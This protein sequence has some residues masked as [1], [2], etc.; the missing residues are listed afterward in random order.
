MFTFINAYPNSKVTRIIKITYGDLCEA[1]RLSQGRCARVTP[2]DAV[3]LE[4]N[5]N[6]TQIQH[7]ESATKFITRF[8]YAKL[9]AKSVGIDI[10]DSLLIDKFLV[11]I[12]SNK[13]YTSLIQTFQTQRR[14]ETLTPNHSLAQLTMTEVEIQ[15][16][17]IDENT[18]T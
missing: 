16:Y 5:F 10:E 14:N 15:V 9:L 7:T 3:R 6:S 18:S 17:T 1:L 11:L 13:H 4:R 2:D 8:R 12:S